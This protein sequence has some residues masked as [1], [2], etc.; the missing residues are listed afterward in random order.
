MISNS[1][2]SYWQAAFQK[3]FGESFELRPGRFIF[4]GKM[5][6]LIDYL[7]PELAIQ[8]LYDDARKRIGIPYDPIAPLSKVEP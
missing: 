7:T 4:R 8:S 2:T 3:Q 1:P 6:L 5:V